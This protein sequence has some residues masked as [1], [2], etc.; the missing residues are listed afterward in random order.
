MVEY[1]FKKVERYLRYGY[2]ASSGRNYTGIICVHHQGGGDKRRGYKID[3]FRR[4]NSF[5]FLYKIK[6]SILFSAL[7]GLIIYQNGIAS[8]ILLVDKMAIGNCIFSGSFIEKE[9]RRQY[10]VSGSSLSLLNVPLFT[11]LCMLNLIH[12]AEV[13]LLGLL[14]R[15]GY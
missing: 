12:Y 2:I 10:I 9:K 14:V 8:Y 11:R 13:S 4:L 6:K 5:G 1:L 7:L 15:L 3:F